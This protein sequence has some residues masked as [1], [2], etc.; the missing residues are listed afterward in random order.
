MN[1]GGSN[2]LKQRKT[3]AFAVVFFSCPKLGKV[4]KMT[5]TKKQYQ[6]K[7]KEERK[8]ELQNT[9]EQLEAGVKAVFTSEHYQNYLTFFAK[10]HDYSFNNVALILAQMP[11]ATLCNSFQTWK[12]MKMPVKKG[13]KGIKILVPI[14]YRQEKL[15]DCKDSQ[16][17]AILNNDGSVKQETAYIDRISFRVGHVFDVSQVDG[18]LPKLTE[19]LKG[20]PPQLA[21]AVKQWI[22][23][24]PIPIAYDNTLDNTETYGYY[25]IT[26]KR[27]ALKK[28][29][30][31]QVF[32]TLCH[33]YAHYLMHGADRAKYTRNEREV[34]A[35]SVAYICCAALG[36]D[37]SSYSFN[38]IA[39]Y[40][41]NREV[42]ELRNSLKLI[43]Q[44]SKTILKFITDNTCL[45]EQEPVAV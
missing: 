43:E 19:S 7:T 44:T 21:K 16:G 12:S 6:S 38:Y 1:I 39:S 14:P 36:L 42:T 45:T 9:L 27:I 18:E 35:E 15:I 34:Q 20:N 28:N 26:E 13:E 25:H 40:S 37:V 3:I 32:K 22:K 5:N 11:T 30:N 41:N 23:T 24:S 10:C 2:T 33:E 31:L 4:E 29:D 17:Q 8:A